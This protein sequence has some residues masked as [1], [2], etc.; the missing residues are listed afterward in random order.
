MG[1]R[2]RVKKLILPIIGRNNPTPPETRAKGQP[3]P[4]PAPRPRPTVIEEEV[5]P[6]GDQ[7]PTEWIKEQVAAAPIYI[8]M[9]GSPV[10]PACGFSANAS[11]ILR[12]YG[13]PLAHCNV[14]LDPDVREAVKDFSSWPTIPQ[15]YIGGEFVGGSD[16]LAEMHGNGELKEMIDALDA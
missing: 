7:D 9:K 12:G 6:R 5:S 14:L 13:K 1:I 2:K 8:F 11:A 3:N 10:Q 15:I 4:R 16:I